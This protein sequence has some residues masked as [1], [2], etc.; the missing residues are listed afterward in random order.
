VGRLVG[1]TRVHPNT[2]TIFGFLLNFGVA[3]L[4]S[5]GQFLPGGL[6]ILAAGI[7]D[8]LDGAVARVMGKVTKFGALLDS[9][10]DRYSEA[11]ILFGLLWYYTWQPGNYTEIILIFTTIIGSLLVSYVRARAEGLNLDA[12]VGI[13]RRTLRITTLSLGLLLSPIDPHLALLVTLWVLAIGTNLTAA[14]RLVYV[15]AKTRKEQ[16]Q[17]TD[18]TE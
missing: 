18:G 6:L 11:V 16:P 1:K 5:Q 10:L 7:F 17:P 8:L 13:F 3:W 2:L 15:W 4:L 12:E 9:T 14:H